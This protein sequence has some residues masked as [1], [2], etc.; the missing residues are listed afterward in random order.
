MKGGIDIQLPVD[1]SFLFPYL[2]TA[3]C[4]VSRICSGVSPAKAD[5][6]SGSSMVTADSPT[7]GSTR[8][9]RAQRQWSLHGNA[10][11][12]PPRRHPWS[13]RG[14]REPCLQ[15]TARPPT[16]TKG[17]DPW[18]RAPCQPAPCSA[19]SPRSPPEIAR[20]RD[21]NLLRPVRP[22]PSTLPGRYQSSHRARRNHG[23][24]VPPTDDRDRGPYFLSKAIALSCVSFVAVHRAIRCSE[25]V[26]VH[27]G[28]GVAPLG[29]PFVIHSADRPPSARLSPENDAHRAELPSVRF[30]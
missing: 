17:D 24:E 10:S 14:S 12:S 13:H 30:P 27:L 22:N 15:G 28:H 19:R 21:P 7:R 3:L 29:Y 20:G 11:K 4:S 23:Y 18:S 25:P 6:T 1:G 5:A 2:L 16:W 26:D 8:V 9:A